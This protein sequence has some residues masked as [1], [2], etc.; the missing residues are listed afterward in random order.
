MT[1]NLDEPTYLKAAQA[2]DQ[3]AF[4][5]LI[6]PYRRQ[7]LV[8][9]YRI[10]GSFE[11]AEDMLQETLVRVWKHLDSFE[12]RSSLRS[13]LYKV[14]TNASLDSLDSRRVRGLPKELYPKGDPAQSLPAPTKEVN[15]V[16][17]FPD[18]WIDDQPNIYPEARY[19]VRE[20]I[21]LAF[22][23]ALQKLPGRQRAVIILCDVMGWSSNEAA[24][25]L[26]MTT[27]A[28]NSALQ[29][30]RETLKQAERKTTPKLLNEQ[31]SALLARY[32]AAWETADSAALIAV[33]REDVALTMPPLPVWFSGHDD[34]KTFLDKFLFRSSSPFKV[35]LEAIRANGSTAFALYQMD[36]GGIYRAAAIHILTIENGQITEINDY[37][38]FDGQLFSRFNLALVV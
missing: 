32:V 11:D 38:T 15:W 18:E 6:D 20:S 17:P 10:L 12:G 13:W 19:E 9:C 21:T 33:L 22:I 31:L 5:Q 23:A 3:E 7:L 29:R 14:A 16:E 24:E 30:A 1:M 8:H 28:V 2:G 37:L 35:K 34:V 4:A 26:D 25:I 36:Q 27:A